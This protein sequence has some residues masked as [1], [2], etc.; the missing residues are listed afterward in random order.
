[1]IFFHF[2]FW[3]WG[4]EYLLNVIQLLAVV[5][6]GYSIHGYCCWNK[7]F[8]KIG[9]VHTAWFEIKIQS[10]DFVVGVKTFS[11]Y[12][13]ACTIILRINVDAGT[14]S[15]VMLQ[16]KCSTQVHVNQRWVPA[17]EQWC[18]GLFN[19]FRVLHKLTLNNKFQLK[20]GRKEK[21]YWNKIIFSVLGPLFP[22]NIFEGNRKKLTCI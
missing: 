21:G 19:I 5:D 3:P 9:S 22:F 20:E 2:P 1:M 13:F 6:I 14:Y 15:L 12:C 18:D 7:F 10:V 11:W 16:Y 17:W 4:A 8:G